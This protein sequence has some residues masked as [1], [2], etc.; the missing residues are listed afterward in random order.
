MLTQYNLEDVKLEIEVSNSD[1]Y[2]VTT[3]DMDN[4][5][6]FI[7][8]AS[9]DAS[10]NGSS[11]PFGICGSKS[12]SFSIFDQDDYLSPNNQESPYFNKIKTGS[13]IKVYLKDTETDEWKNDGTYYITS[14]SG[15]FNEGFCNAVNIYCQD[16]I[17]NIG[18][19]ANP[20][21]PCIKN[22]KVEDF[23]SIL[24]T[25]LNKGTDWDIDP[26]LG[27]IVLLYGIT[28]GDKI[29]D[30]LNALA[31]FLQATITINRDDMLVIRSATKIYGNTYTLPYDLVE[32]LSNIYNSAA[33][34]SKI[35]I[36][37]NVDG[38]KVVDVLLNDNSYTFKNGTN[39]PID[40]IKFLTK[41]L[42]IH[43]IQIMYDRHRYNSSLN[44]NGYQAYQDG[45]DGLSVTVSG[46][47][48]EQCTIYVEGASIDKSTRNEEKVIYDSNNSGTSINIEIKYIIKQ[49]EAVSL[50]NS[51]ANLV[52]KM[53]KQ[54]TIKT[55]ASPHIDLGDRIILEDDEYTSSYKGSYRVIKYQTV[56]GEN[57]SNILTLIRE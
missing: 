20:K 41:A 29:R 54:I 28:V 26:N 13:K 31:H 51:L 42:S 24:L 6:R 3:N 34:Y 8:A 12:Y 37:Y 50:V 44:I 7:T 57:Y 17:N 46:D 5:R 27:S 4:E 1:P 45:M 14:I 10:D 39:T 36:N 16:K 33:N 38:F 47:D 32:D 53:T 2:V 43:N 22:I 19:N 18:S 23:L 30:T 49:S 52:D 15:S 11:N 25:G 40:N 9:V 35:T 21:I 48:I 56:H 55:I